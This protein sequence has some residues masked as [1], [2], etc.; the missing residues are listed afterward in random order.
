MSVSNTNTHSGT[1]GNLRR[2]MLPN[3]KEQQQ[4]NDS[5]KENVIRH[6]HTHTHTH[7]HTEDMRV[8]NGREGGA[9]GATE[10][11]GGARRG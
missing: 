5:K 9:L 4:K 7:S 2:E 10:K 1:P 11:R 8:S 6:T 3:R